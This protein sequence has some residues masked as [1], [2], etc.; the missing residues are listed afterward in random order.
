GAARLRTERDHAAG[1]RCEGRQR[2]R[3]SCENCHSIA[4]SLGPLAV[5]RASMYGLALRGRSLAMTMGCLFF[6]GGLLAALALVATGASAE[7]SEASQRG[8][9]L[10]LRT[11]WAFPMGALEKA[12]RQS[13]N[14]SGMLPVWFDAG[15]RWSEQFY[16][17]GY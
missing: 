9:S 2:G 14:F 8:L 16:A 7:T 1:C 4:R 12:D 13:S 10:G 15:Y 17:G 5:R 6:S 11:G 3:T